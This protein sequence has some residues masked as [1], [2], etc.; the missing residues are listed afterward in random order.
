MMK[1]RE[2]FVIFAPSGISD[3]KCDFLEKM[4]KYNRQIAAHF[5]WRQIF[6]DC[7]PYLL[8]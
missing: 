3:F 4:S 6:V 7:G 1:V 8:K 2:C 5:P